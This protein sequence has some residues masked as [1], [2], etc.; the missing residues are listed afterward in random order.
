MRST[1]ARLKKKYNDPAGAG[2]QALKQNATDLLLGKTTAGTLVR[3][4]AAEELL[5]RFWRTVANKTRNR[6]WYFLLLSSVLDKLV[7]TTKLYQRGKG[8]R[9]FYS[10][11]P[12]RL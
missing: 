4:A 12:R 5:R 1:Q 11:V 7:I 6:R 3:G 10:D 9:D 2:R 8:C